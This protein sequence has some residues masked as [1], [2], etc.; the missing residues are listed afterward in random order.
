MDQKRRL[1]AQIKDNLQKIGSRLNGRPMTVAFIGSVGVGK[2]S[3][4]NT[5][6]TAMGTGCW[7]QHAYTGGH[8]GQADP[9]TTVIRRYPQCCRPEEHRN[10][11]FP[12]LIDVQ[13]LPE[14]LEGPWS[15]VLSL[16][17]YGRIPEEENLHD[18]IGYLQTRDDIR[19]PKYIRGR[20]RLKVDRVVVVA[21]AT[22][23]LPVDLLQS[24]VEIARPIQGRSRRGIPIFGVMT[25]S[26][27]VDPDVD[28]EYLQKEQRFK[29]ILGLQG[30]PRFLRCINY[31]SDIDPDN[32]MI[33]QSYPYLDVPVLRLMTQICDPAIEVVHQREPYPY[34][35]LTREKTFWILMAV[36]V[37]F[38]A[39]ALL[40][41]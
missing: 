20:D 17:F 6:A 39:F 27:L 16:L 34:Q 11:L 22:Q 36:V 37:I 26:D 33:F 5:I 30:T 28:T 2:S 19:R 35:H 9:V 3:L 13:G 1:Q 4:I 12:T 7:Q 24:I 18:V 23:L 32:N 41:R 25:K 29:D 10:P 31:C 38:L 40:L 21:S 15:D 14:H 8:G